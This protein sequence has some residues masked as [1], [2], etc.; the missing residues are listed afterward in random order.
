MPNPEII[1][2]RFKA[3][4][5]K[6]Q[7]KNRFYKYFHTGKWEKQR[8]SKDDSDGEEDGY[9]WSC[10]LNTS[11]ESKGCAKILIDKNKGDYSS[12]TSWWS[13]INSPI[14]N[15]SEIKTLGGKYFLV[16]T[17]HM[18]TLNSSNP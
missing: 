11:K 4:L 18:S 12:Y 17:W 7:K 14:I 9:G 8:E 15:Y 3:N 16:A 5:T 6:A 13:D 2:N 1:N 10:C